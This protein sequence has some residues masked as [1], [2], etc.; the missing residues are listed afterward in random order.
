MDLM[1]LS[2]KKEAVCPNEM[3]DSNRKLNM[4]PQMLQVISGQEIA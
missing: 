1:I 3:V 4:W 2:F